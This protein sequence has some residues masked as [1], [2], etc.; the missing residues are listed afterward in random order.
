MVGN[1]EETFGMDGNFDWNRAYTG[2]GKR[3]LEAADAKVLE[4]IDALH[5]GRALDLGCGAGGLAIELACR[6]WQVVGV[7][8]AENAI[9]S[10]RK[11][12]E[13]R[14]VEVD[15]EVADI[16]RWT[17]VGTFDLITS[18]FALPGSRE[19]RQSVLRK[20]ADALEP[21]GTLVVAEWE[22]STVDF[23]GASSDD[24][25]TSLDEVLSAIEGL[26]IERAQIC[27]VPAHDHSRDEEH[28]HDHGK[29]AAEPEC[30]DWKAFYVRAHRAA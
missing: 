26:A 20:A 18:C 6:G 4:L 9:A 30:S 25:W 15:L 24:L 12:V 7:D 5:P 17:P 21:G 23:Q 8:I 11:N 22:G 1:V 28:S 16:S 14:A 19:A 2:Q 13:Q 3:D 29:D 10:A 27:N